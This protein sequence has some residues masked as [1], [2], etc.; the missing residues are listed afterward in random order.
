MW[1]GQKSSHNFLL[2]QGIDMG[3][4][5]VRYKAEVDFDGRELTRSYLDKQDL[6][7]MLEEVGNMRNINEMEA[8]M[9]KHGEN[10]G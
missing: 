6:E 2:L 8:F 10:I 5:L 9:L 4:G 1:S 7:M 3:S